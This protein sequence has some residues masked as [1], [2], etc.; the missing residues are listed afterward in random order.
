MIIRNETK[1][2]MVLQHLVLFELTRIVMRSG[3]P[4]PEPVLNDMIVKTIPK[5][6]RDMVIHQLE[7]GYRP[8]SKAEAQRR[9]LARMEQDP[10]LFADVLSQTSVEQ[11][12]A[13][14]GVK[15]RQRRQDMR[16]IRAYERESRASEWRIKNAKE[17]REAKLAAR[18]RRV[19]QG[20]A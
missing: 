15:K 2:K 16:K 13:G 18:I 11:C 12:R 4:Y 8:S 3:K 1:Y 9:V 20:R 19:E 14:M 17:K 5:K 7:D 6:W 10:R